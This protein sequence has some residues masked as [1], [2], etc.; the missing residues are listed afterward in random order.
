MCV[1]P[2]EALEYCLDNLKEIGG[3]RVLVSLW[4][5]TGVINLHEWQSM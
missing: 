5:E 1:D 4:K 3:E 2:E